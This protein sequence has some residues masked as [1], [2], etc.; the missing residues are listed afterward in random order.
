MDEKVNKLIVNA[1]QEDNY[2][3]D[4]VTNILI[5]KNKVVTG[6]LVACTSGIVSGT[7]VVKALYK[8]LNPKMNI[9]IH[10][11]NGSFINRGTV[12][13]TLKGPMRDILRGEQLAINLITRMS[14][15]ATL[16]N[17]YVTEIKDLK[18]QILDTRNTT[19][20]LRILD[21]QAVRDGGGVNYQFNL[22]DRLLI[23]YSHVLTNDNL[24]EI[25]DK[26]KN[27]SKI[28]LP[29]EIEIKTIDEYYML[30]DTKCDVIILKDMND[31]IIKKIVELNK[32]RKKLAVFGDFSIKKVRSIAKMGIE[33]IIIDCLTHSY[34]AMD[35]KMRFYKNLM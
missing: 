16:T 27:N 3:S 22:G 10:H 20:L 14:G 33:Y 35:I 5:E 18:C 31:E 4:I 21:K 30:E 28:D 19:P 7:D 32:N 8:H 9:T 1:L 11:D 26:V 12:I 2:N 29:L 13:M 34:K 25:I 15:I 24:P 17:Q 23:R 6:N